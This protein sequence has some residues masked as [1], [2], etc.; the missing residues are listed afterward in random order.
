[1]TIEQKEKISILRHQGKSYSYIATVLC[2]SKNIISSYCKR[3]NLGIL[4]KTKSQESNKNLCREC[5][6]L[7]VK[8]LKG[9]PKKFCSDK[10]RRKW[11]K[12]NGHELEKKAYYVFTCANCGKKFDSYGNKSRKYCSHSCYIDARF[13]EGGIVDVKRAI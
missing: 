9:Q 10:C 12:A 5:G 3:N 6:K 7:L 4:P 11:W 1:M 8:G 2:V 13:K